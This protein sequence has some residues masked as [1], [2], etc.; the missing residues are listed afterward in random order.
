VAPTG[1]VY[2]AYHSVLNFSG[3][4]PANGD[5]AVFV[6][7]YNADLT[8]AVRTTALPRGTADITFNVQNN[9]APRKIP[10]A[11]FWTQGSAQ[12]WVLADPVRPGNVYVIANSAN[13]FAGSF[14]DIRI[15]RS[16]N[17]GATWTNSIIEGGANRSEFFPNAAIDRFGDIVVA[18]YDNRRGLPLNPQ[19]HFRLDVYAKYS[20]DGGLTFSPAFAVNDQTA[21][22]N[23]MWGNVFDPDPGAVQRFPGPPPTTRIGEYFGIGLWGGTAYVAWNGNTF[24]SFGN[25]NGEQVWTKAF[26]IRGALTVTGTSGNDTITV[27]NMAGNS[28][29]VEVLVNG[30]RQY[31]GLWS[32][33]TGISIAPTAGND[34]INLEDVAAGVPVSVTLGSGSD[35]VNLGPVAASLSNILSNVTVTGGSGSTSLVALDQ[36]SFTS[37]TFTLAAGSLARAGGPTVTYS[38]VTDLFL[39][40]GA[41]GNTFN[42]NGTSAGTGVYF[43]GGPGNNTVNGSASAN[44]WILFGPNQSNLLGAAYGNAV[45]FAD[46]GNLRAGPSGDYFQ[47]LNGATISG[48][49]VGR[50]NGLDFVDWGNYST[51]VIV[52]LQTGFATGV[53]GTVSGIS[54]L[55]GGSGVGAP[56]VYNLLIGNGGDNLYGGFGRRNLLVAGGSAGV[57]IG[58]DG[59][60]LFVGGT[61]IYDTQA[62][63]ASWQAIAAYW[64]G[65]TPYATRASNVIN[66]VGVPRLDATTVTG[67]GG[68][69]YLREGGGLG[70]VYTDGGDAV[71]NF[72][73]AS[74]Q[75]M[76]TP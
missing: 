50:G 5:G 67:N 51:S 44:T 15:A 32:S 26:S 62:G 1:Q 45:T 30:Q 7:R 19:G 18:W 65:S 60:D 46:I 12:P 9:G 47:V 59:E 48:N 71:V 29:F 52:D 36:S 76:I 37:Q 31:A 66:G 64:A 4:N 73:P 56:G 39:Y 34:T 13:N 3:P 6:T 43:D 21:G 8:G 72:D 58:G 75:V 11:Q 28:A 27:R 22:V 23:T 74:R 17:S 70:L 53:G 69:N 10:G 68:G 63:L 25:P 20:T 38:G 16:T 40:A 35:T 61:T 42:M 33:L 24:A 57:L 55:S 54:N 49:L 2:V 41:G 14:G